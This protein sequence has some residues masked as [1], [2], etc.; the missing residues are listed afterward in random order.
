MSIEMTALRTVS[1]TTSVGSSSPSRYIISNSSLC[2]ATA[3]K[4]TIRAFLAAGLRSSGMSTSSQVEPWVASSKMNALFE[5]R[6]MWPRNISPSPIG[7]WTGT[8]LAPSRSFIMAMAF[9]KLA[10]VRSILLTNAIRGTLYLS[11]CRQTVSDWGSTPPTEQNRAT[12]PSSTRRLRSTST[13]KS[14]WPGVSMMLIRWPFHS[15]VVAADVIVM[16]RSF[17]CSIQSI[18][19]PPSWTSPI[20]C[21]LPV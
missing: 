18:V 2:S 19:A 21:V 15:A 17:S 11:I 10:P 20:R 14:T 16:P 1:L 5:I 8:A 6:S 13:V 7:I 4:R 9:S 3:S 12:A